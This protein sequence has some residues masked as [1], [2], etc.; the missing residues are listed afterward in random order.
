MVFDL[1]Y[2]I[3]D[4]FVYFILFGRLCLSV[5]GGES[6]LVAAR[7]GQVP[8][9][10]PRLIDKNDTVAY[11]PNELLGRVNI[12]WTIGE[13]ILFSNSKKDTIR[14]ETCWSET[15]SCLLGIDKYKLT[16]L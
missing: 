1:L 4:N 14:H 13:E 2:F 9:S 7:Q 6:S 12:G 16:F 15:D 10:S 3:R 5:P 11:N 8:A